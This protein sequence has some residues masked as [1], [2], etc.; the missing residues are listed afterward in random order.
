MK[1]YVGNLPFK[2]T[3][4]DLSEAFG[5]FGHV[6]SASIISDKVTKRS[7]GFGF[8]EMTNEDEAHAAIKAMDGASFQSRTIKVNE[9]RPLT[10]RPPR[11]DSGR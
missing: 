4:A 8:V 1:I 10:D 6:A 11:R 9:A 7:R 5:R 2:T 3:E